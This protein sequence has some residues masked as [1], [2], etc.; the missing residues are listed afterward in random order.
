MKLIN[1]I[2]YEAAGCG[3]CIGEVQAG[4]KFKFNPTLAPK[5]NLLMKLTKKASTSQIN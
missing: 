4:A 5:I 3:R 2:L 1:K